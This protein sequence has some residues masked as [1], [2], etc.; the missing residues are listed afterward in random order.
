MVNG[1]SVVRHTNKSYSTAFQPKDSP[2]EKDEEAESACDSTWRPGGLLC[3]RLVRSTKK[4]VLALH[5]EE[6]LRQAIEEAGGLFA[7]SLRDICDENPDD[8]SW[9]AS[10]RRA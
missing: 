10:P 8:Y 9:P 5:L 4:Q 2:V 7:V 3:I 1:E 6:Q